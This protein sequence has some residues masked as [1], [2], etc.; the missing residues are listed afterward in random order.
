MKSSELCTFPWNRSLLS[1]YTKLTVQ[2]RFKITHFDLTSFVRYMICGNKVFVVN[3]RT[4]N[5]LY[6]IA[7]TGLYNVRHSGNMGLYASQIFWSQKMLKDAL[8][9]IITMLL[10]IYH[11]LID[12]IQYSN[13]CDF[14]QDVHSVYRLEFERK[15]RLRSFPVTRKVSL[16][17][18]CI[19]II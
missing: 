10:S 16:I 14:Q 4:G 12:V 6:L 19:I 13:L 15:W 2:I 11:H 8:F 17:I 3:I 9:S 18:V 5:T 1:V 7:F